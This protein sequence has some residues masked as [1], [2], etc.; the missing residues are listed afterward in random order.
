MLNQIKQAV[1]RALKREE[2]TE[3]KAA[4]KYVPVPIMR[5]YDAAKDSDLL[6]NWRGSEALSPA[7]IR[8]ELPIVRKKCLDLFLNSALCRRAMQI[9]VNNIVGEG[10]KIAANV[11]SKDGRADNLNA[12]D[13]LED[14]WNLWAKT[15]KYCHTSKQFTLTQI[16]KKAVNS[17]MLDGEAFLKISRG[18]NGNPFGV[19]VDLIRADFVAVDYVA[20]LDEAHEVKNGVEVNSKTGEVLAYWLYCEVSATGRPYGHKERIPA[21]DILHLYSPETIGQLRG[22]PIFASVASTIK[23]LDAYRVATI[24]A[25]RLASMSVGVWKMADSSALDPLQVAE[26]GDDGNLQASKSPGENVICPPGWSFESTTPQFPTATYDTFNLALIRDI[27]SG[28]GVSNVSLSQDLQGVSYS[29]IRQSELENRRNFIAWQTDLIEMV[30]QPL[31]EGVGNWLDC[32]ALKH[33][34][35][36][37][38]IEEM[39]FAVS[40]QGPRWQNIDIQSEATAM[41]LLADENIISKEAWAKN[42]GFDYYTNLANA[43]DEKQWREKLELENKSEDKTANQ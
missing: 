10:I 1:K 23:Q 24:T 18:E 21:A 2:K 26:L 13:S 41:K 40:W 8:N 30:I 9:Y 33:D 5:G 6:A 39:R 31:F 22:F 35:P 28:L 7:L 34:V 38:D 19:S 15:P 27:A 11:K 43:R 32:Y 20:K 42:L 12:S 36:F 29:S 25:S 3:P 14:A 16:L 17:W 37:A 4:I